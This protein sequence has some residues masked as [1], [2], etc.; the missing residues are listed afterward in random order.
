[1]KHFLVVVD[2]QND[3]VNGALGTAEA[4]AMLP[5]AC[6]KIKEWDGDIF[7]TYDT[8]FENYMDTAEGAKLP[9]KHC[10]KGTAGW[11]LNAQ[12]AAALEEK[13]YVSVE[14]ITF[15]STVLPTLI[16]DAMEEEGFDEN[17]EITLIGLCTDICVVSNA[18]ILKANFPEAYIAVDSACCAGV[19][20][21]T[22]EAALTTMKMCQIDVL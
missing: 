13:D 11:E 9:V 3:F 2:I 12:I 14:K 22:H 8:H 18:L 4:V 1:M 21:E 5:A 17:F 20:P 16:E 19:T 7:V 15:G 6:K 10:I